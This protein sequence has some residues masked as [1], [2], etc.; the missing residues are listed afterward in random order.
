MAFAHTPYDGSKQP[1]TIGAEPLDPAL[2]IEP[3][4]HLAR[5]LALKDAILDTSYD[6][7]VRILPGTEA[8]QAELRDLLVT[9]LLSE[10]PH[11]YRRAGDAIEI[12]P[13]GR[14]VAL[15]ASA[16]PVLVHCARLVQDDLCLMRR[17]P[18]G[19]RLVAGVLCFPSGWSLA[20][21]IGGDLT[22]I[23]APVPGFEGRMAETVSR[24]FDRMTP[25]RPVVRWNWSIYGNEALR[26]EPSAESGW[27]RFPPGEALKGAHLRIERQTLRRLPVSGDLVFTIRIHSDAL[28]ALAHHPDCARLADGLRAQVIALD[29]AQ[30]AYKGLAPVKD[31]L[32][33]WLG[34]MVDP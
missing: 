8:A 11:L 26:Q 17:E 33:A 12:P 15:D 21:K 28:S 29:P 7:A 3:D 18:D 2:W 24:M 27:T 22:H 13:L 19:W 32:I 25:E 34:R 10:H 9:H 23:H 31:D 14:T 16:E 1:F 4:R 20:E 6:S 30:L 5:D